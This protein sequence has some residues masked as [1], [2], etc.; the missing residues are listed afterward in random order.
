MKIEIQSW[1]TVVDI[2]IRIQNL[3]RIYKKLNQIAPIEK[4]AL[5]M[6]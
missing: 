4:F 6:R 1:Y 2:L 3:K 5:I